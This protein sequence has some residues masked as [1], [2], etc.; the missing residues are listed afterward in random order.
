MFKDGDYAEGNV[1]NRTPYQPNILTGDRNGVLHNP[2]QLSLV[3]K[4]K[5]A[6]LY[7]LQHTLARRNRPHCTIL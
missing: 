6:I 1:K 4:E 3:L 2:L 7:I 5:S